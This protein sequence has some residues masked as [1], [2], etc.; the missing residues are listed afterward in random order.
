MNLLM[1]VAGESTTIAKVLEDLGSVFTFLMD[2]V[3][4]VFSTIQTYPIALIPI[5]AGI[6]FICVRFAK[7]ILNI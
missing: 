5:G 1:E 3:G 6:A 7:N 4:N 2:K